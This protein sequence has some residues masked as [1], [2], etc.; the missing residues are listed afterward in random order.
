M[1]NCN[2]NHG[3]HGGHGNCNCKRQRRIARKTR[4]GNC[5]RQQQLQIGRGLTR[6][7]ADK[8]NSTCIVGI[9]AS[10]LDR[11]TVGLFIH[12]RQAHW[13]SASW[14]SAL[15]APFK[16]HLPVVAVH[17]VM[18]SSR[19]YSCPSCSFMSFMFKAV[20]KPEAKRDPEECH[21]A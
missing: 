19:S 5:K 2:G 6:T 3:S 16:P 15:G 9:S 1:K 8:C 10:R 11:Q 4:M 17:A 13:R 21:R 14:R 12:R 20:G 7:N 18:K